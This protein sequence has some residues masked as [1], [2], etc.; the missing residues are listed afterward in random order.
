MGVDVDGER[1]TYRRRVT[2]PP[3]PRWEQ[4]LGNRHPVV[5]FVSLYVIENSGVRLLASILRE[6]GIQVHE[7]YFKDWVNNRVEPPSA[8]ETALLMRELHRIRPDL[9]GISVR[10]SAFHRMATDLTV[11]IRRELDVPILWGGMHPTSL[12]EDCA[13]VADLISVGEAEESVAELFRRLAADEDPSD[14][15]GLWL[16]TADGL[17]RNGAAPLVQ[18]L[19]ALPFRD[20]HSE[21]KCFID[22]RRVIPG[23]PYT[24]E[25]I[26]LVMASRGCPFPS[27][28]FCSNS[29]MDRV[30]PG[31]Q[32]YRLRSLDDVFEEVSY[33]R[34]TFPNLRRF[35]F[36]DEE[37][38]VEKAW[39][40][41]F[42]RRWPVEAG[43]PFEIHMDPRVVTDE[44]LRRLKAAGMDTVFMGIQHTAEV[45]R[46]IYCR[47]VSDDQVLRAA[48]AIHGAGVRAGYQVIL[49]DPVSTEE[50]KSRLFDL[51]M[52]L[53]RP[54]EM[55]LFSLAIYPGSALAEELLRRGLITE[56]DIEGQ[57]TKVFDQFRVDLSYARTE[58]DRF[59]TGLV[60]LVSKNFVPKR[61]LRRMSR[62]RRLAAHPDV[63]IAMAYGANVVKIGVMGVDLVRKGEMSWGVVRRWLSLK[64][65]VT[66]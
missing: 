20:F 66:F 16:H 8:A 24:V 12:P 65:L 34:R 28:A 50:D 6:Q 61:L 38:P 14:I 10:A 15:A 48:H 64:S 40:D 44:R 13:H 39:F 33:A 32:Y 57:A 11:R 25:P 51:L 52:Q 55:V 36:D 62:S 43:M 60:V 31:Q 1:A 17:V 46:E 47:N 45:N 58:S 59:W 5:A 63:V 9:V 4:L 41:E 56:A 7:L 26:Y 49:D 54:Y 35:R 27:C 22:G 19:D 30:V 21:D 23:D 18:D 42:C 37:F 3:G 2:P 53:P 29:V